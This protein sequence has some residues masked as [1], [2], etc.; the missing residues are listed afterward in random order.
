MNPWFGN[1]HFA[2]VFPGAPG[3]SV[4]QTLDLP[5]FDYDVNLF[6]SYE[7]SIDVNAVEWN[8][9]GPI[10]IPGATYGTSYEDYEILPVIKEVSGYALRSYYRKVF[11]KAGQASLKV[12]I[13][14][15][16]GGGVGWGHGGVAGMTSI[17]AIAFKA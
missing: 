10:Q 8:P 4:N 1:K 12:G 14:L 9:G 3:L 16:G 15:N 5:T 2:G 6:V 17:S 7:I 13:S 11:V